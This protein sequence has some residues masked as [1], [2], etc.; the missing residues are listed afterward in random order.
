MADR[1]GTSGPSQDGFT[2]GY[3]EWSSLFLGDGALITHVDA[4]QELPDIFVLYMAFLFKRKGN[5]LQ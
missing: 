3:M 5:L 1:Y 4:I 2:T